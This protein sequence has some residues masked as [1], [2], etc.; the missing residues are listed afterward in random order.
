MRQRQRCRPGF[1]SAALAAAS[2]CGGGLVAAEAAAAAAA[3]AGPR[4]RHSPPPQVQPPQVDVGVA[5]GGPQAQGG[6]RTAAWEW[7]SLDSVWVLVML[8]AA[9]PDCRP[10][11]LSGPAPGH[12]EDPGAPSACGGH[13]VVSGGRL[14]VAQL[15]QRVGQ[16]GVRLGA[17]GV[18]QDRGIEQRQRQLQAAQLVG[19][20]ASQQ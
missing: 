13:L 6:L 19:R 15:S 12:L 9:L 1:A 11:S 14:E 17:G 20:G 10:R 5:E 3:A 16:V 7:E 18:R 8:H 4:L 2:S